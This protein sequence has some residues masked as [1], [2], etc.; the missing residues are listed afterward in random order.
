MDMMTLFILTAVLVGITFYAENVNLEFNR[1]TSFEPL[2][3]AISFE[4]VWLNTLSTQVKDGVVLL[5]PNKKPMSFNSKM[6]QLIEMKNN[7]VVLSDVEH[8]KSMRS[9]FNYFFSLDNSRAN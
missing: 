8:P 1:Q 2:K 5:G 7:P 4:E 9:L 6:N 3:R